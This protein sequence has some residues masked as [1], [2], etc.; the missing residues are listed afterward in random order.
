VKGANTDIDIELDG[1]IN[2]Q[3][4]YG[5]SVS[6]HNILR[7]YSFNWDEIPGNDTKRFIKCLKQKYGINWVETA[8]IEK[9]DNSKTIKV[10]TGK[11]SIS[12]ILNNKKTKVSLKINDG[13]TDKFTAKME[14]GEL[15]MYV[16]CDVSH[17]GGVK[18]DWD[19]DEE[20]IK[21]KLMQLPNS[22]PGFLIRYN[23]NMDF[24]LPEWEDVIEDNKA[25]IEFYRNGIQNEA[26][27]YCSN[28]FKHTELA[29]KIAL[30]LGF[31]IRWP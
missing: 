14:N 29:Y 27:L 2:I 9:I 3:V 22:K 11:N 1:N 7:K 20:K 23:P 30:A 10:S 31:R 17:L 13:R 16:K 15:N 19:K 21:K 6:T 8:K 26:C 18:T 4:W 12:L 24:F 25:I 5:A 28:G